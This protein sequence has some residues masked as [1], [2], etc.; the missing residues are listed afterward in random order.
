MLC[1]YYDNIAN[2]ICFGVTRIQTCQL[3]KYVYYH[4][5][6]FKVRIKINN[7]QN[8]K[9]FLNLKT[10]FQRSRARLIATLTNLRPKTLP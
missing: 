10:R 5:T 6:D 7:T 8:N 1:K 2:F 9:V 3:E 4:C